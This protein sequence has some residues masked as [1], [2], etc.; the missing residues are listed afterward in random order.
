MQVASLLATHVR[1]TAANQADES[2]QLEAAINRSAGAKDR[3][4]QWRDDKTLP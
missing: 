2:V 4:Y 3:F 1:R